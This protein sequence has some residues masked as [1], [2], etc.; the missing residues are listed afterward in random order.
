MEVGKAWKIETKNEILNNCKSLKNKTKLLRGVWVV[1]Q[2]S[3]K[4]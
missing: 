3:F 1:L 4:K 2:K